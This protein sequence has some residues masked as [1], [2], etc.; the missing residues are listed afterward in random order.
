MAVA[1][2]ARIAFPGIY[3]GLLVETARRNGLAGE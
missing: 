3:S 1:E 2:Q